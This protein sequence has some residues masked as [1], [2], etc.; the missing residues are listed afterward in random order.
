MC[1]RDRDGHIEQALK[2]IVAAL[3]PA[4]AV[5]IIDLAR[6]IT[7]VALCEFFPFDLLIRKGFY[8]PDAA[9]RILQ[10]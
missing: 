8:D 10:R 7:F 4:H 6:Q 2:E 5:I 9:Q 1:I 3:E